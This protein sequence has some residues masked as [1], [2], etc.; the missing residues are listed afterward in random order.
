MLPSITESRHFPTTTAQS[1][2]LEQHSQQVLD[3]DA[4]I[5]S[6]EEERPGKGVYRTR[7]VGRLSL[8][9]DGES[10]ELVLE[11][12]EGMVNDCRL[13]ENEEQMTVA[14]SNSQA[15]AACAGACSS[16][17]EQTSGRG[18][19]S[20][21][22]NNL[23]MVPDVVEDTVRDEEGVRTTHPTVEDA[24]CKAISEECNSG[25]P[26]T[27]MPFHSKNA[28]QMQSSLTKSSGEMNECLDY[29]RISVVSVYR[30]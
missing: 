14:S 19:S 12:K 10:S 25:Q 11:D 23:L 16:I 7:R 18:A 13:N 9:S 30:L 27:F 6:K 24:C 28:P 26:Q 15:S 17:A 2:T 1:A 22:I 8:D 20:S 5:L 3:L 29:C 21:S 4:R